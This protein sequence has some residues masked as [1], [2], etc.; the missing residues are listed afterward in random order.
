MWAKSK[1]KGYGQVKVNGGKRLAHRLFYE[2]A[3]G[4]IPPGHHLHH[5][6]GNTACVRPEHLEPLT[7]KEHRRR[8][9][10]LSVAAARDIRKRVAF[11]EQGASLAREY[12][13]SSSA[14]W[15]LIHGR[16]WVDA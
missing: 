6:C 14:V 1:V 7:P 10:K 4:P 9:A 11:G 3:R 16:S 15:N 8:S 12:G 5:L 2:R 13:V